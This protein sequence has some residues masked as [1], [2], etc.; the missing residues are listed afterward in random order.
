MA[1]AFPVSPAVNDVHTDGALSWR[2]DGVKWV[3]VTGSSGGGGGAQNTISYFAD[4]ALGGHRVVRATT[5]GNVGY[6]DPSDP[7]QAHAALG[8]TVG[9][10][11][12]GTAVEVQYAG[13]MTEPSWSWTANLPIFVGAAGVPTQTPPSVG[14]H[15]PIGVAVSATSMVIQIKTPVVL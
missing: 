4:G 8:L 9:A 6:V 12:G 1:L 2:W 11:S 13:A 5:P 7:A 15:A 14:F 3:S 10:A